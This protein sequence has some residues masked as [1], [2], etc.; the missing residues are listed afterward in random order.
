[1]RI[2]VKIGS[3]IIA[4]KV[5]GLNARR[6]AA[7]SGAISKV[8]DAGHEVIVVSSG[9]VA[10]GMRKLGLKSKPVE[11][12]LKQ[13]AAAAGQ[14]SLI[15]AY[16]KCFARHSKKV[17]QV[18][19]TRDTL[20]DRK[21]YLNARNTLITLLDYKVIPI[22]NEN[23]TIAVDEIRFGDNDNLASLVSMLVEANHMVILSDVDGLYSA[24][25][26]EDPAATLIA[27]VGRITPEIIAKAGGSSSAVGTGGMYSKV[28]AAKKAMHS[29]IAV[30]IL[31]GAK[32]KLLT[33]LLVDGKP[34]GTAF[35]PEQAR[36]N[37]RK[38]W[39]AYGIRTR[40]S[41]TVDAG[42][43]RA[44]TERGRSLLPSGIVSV[45][46]TFH[47]GDAIK[48]MDETGRAIA[49]GITNYSSDEL[50]KIRGLKTPQIEKTLGYC[51]S[52]EAIHRDNLVVLEHE[53]G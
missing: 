15:Q 25:P 10:A 41:I 51:Y 5:T 17:A 45:E 50:Q 39:I 30:N 2:V 20:S 38:G 11:I 34:C 42:A 35:A 13:A 27:Q 40:G 7:L 23:D 44:V 4:D 19:L 33:A 16:E 9:A 14:A 47:S 43:A 48:C 12:K 8:Q 36:F 32:P 37:A 21:M 26:T 22:I 6:I 29:G 31:N 28:M 18:L 24:N 49:K 53:Q 1:M 46:G 52:D 3:N